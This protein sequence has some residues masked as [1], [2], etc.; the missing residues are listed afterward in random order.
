MR[1][2]ACGREKE[3][4]EMLARGHWPE[5]ASGELR[6]H[7]DLCRGCRDLVLVKQAFR[8]ERSAAAN[9]ARLEPPGVLW[10]R[11]QLRR[12]NAA[13]VS[14]GKPILG[15][16]IFSVAVTLAAAILYL[17][18]QGKRGYAMPAWLQQFPRALHLEALLP[19]ALAKYPVETWLVFSGLA[20]LAVMSGVIVYMASE[21]H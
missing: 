12:R 17:A 18:W 16:Q 13:L 20:M 21:K 3:V 1:L 11:A 8:A 6:A 9:A 14:M 19:D 10:W 15:A 5:A 7:V 4:A 2:R